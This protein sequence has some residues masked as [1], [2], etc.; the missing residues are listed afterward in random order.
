MKTFK[1]SL[2]VLSKIVTSLI[3]IIAAVLL[4]NYFMEDRF[5]FIFTGGF[6]ML[7]ILF[8]FLYMPQKYI[9]SKEELIITRIIGNFKV[10]RKNILKVI[11]PDRSYLSFVVRVFGNSGLFG[12]TG[13]FWNKSFGKMHWFVT[14]RKNYV[15]ID[16]GTKRKIVLSPDDYDGL[17][18]ALQNR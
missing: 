4:Y 16:M 10:E 12:Y 3:A 9:V 2:D 8:M 17:I 7:L 13:Y 11:H 1:A 18:D 15:V 5:I 6:L 14:Q